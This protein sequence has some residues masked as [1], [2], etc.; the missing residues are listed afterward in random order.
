MSVQYI[1]LGED[2]NIKALRETILGVSSSIAGGIAMRRKQQ[3]DLAMQAMKAAHQNYLT[4]VGI[5]SRE[6]IHRENL[7][8]RKAEFNEEKNKK[9]DQVEAA[10]GLFDFFN[11]TGEDSYKYDSSG[12]IQLNPNSEELQKNLTKVRKNPS[13]ALS[14][15]PALKAQKEQ[16]KELL[17]RMRW[18]KAAYDTDKTGRLKQL[19][20][21]TGKE[22]N[23][24]S[25]QLSLP[26]VASLVKENSIWEELVKER[27]VG[28]ANISGL[29]KAQLDRHDDFL[30]VKN[31]FVVNGQSRI[32]E[33]WSL[34][35]TDQRSL[36]LAFKKQS[37]A[38][39]PRFNPKLQSHDSINAQ[40]AQI[41]DPEKAA[42]VN[43]TKLL[44]DLTIGRIPDA[45][46]RTGFIFG[47]PTDIVNRI[48]IN[49]DQGIKDLAQEIT[50]NTA[51]DKK[52]PPGP[53]GINVL[54]GNVDNDALTKKLREFNIF[55]LG[56]NKSDKQHRLH[57][58]QGMIL[59]DQPDPKSGLRPSDILLALTI[60]KQG[61]PGRYYGEFLHNE[62]N[63]SD[64]ARI[65]NNIRTGNVPLSDLFLVEIGNVKK[66]TAE[67]TAP[68]SYEESE[69]STPFM[70]QN[71]K[72]GYEKAPILGDKIQESFES[73]GISTDAET[74]K[75]LEGVFMDVLPEE[76]ILRGANNTL[77][78]MAGSI[79]NSLYSILV[80]Q[81]SREK[82]KGINKE[83]KKGGLI[84]KAIDGYM[85]VLVSPQ[86]FPVL[87]STIDEHI[88]TGKNWQSG[89]GSSLQTKVEELRTDGN[90]KNFIREMDQLVKLLSYRSSE[91]GW[92]RLNSI[93]LG[94]RR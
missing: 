79:D 63:L 38:F 59:G 39:D 23:N 71:A 42:S 5:E 30:K 80:N 55:E 10:E 9:K 43:T 64:A 65:G 66:N 24:E 54:L 85:N 81:Q 11:G 8:Q 84:D 76:S 3:N 1:E 22:I 61:I 6:K 89:T 70:M 13:V 51:V 41:S 58:I 62:D 12:H 26:L 29:N 67:E 34:F 40:I 88:K 92:N 27:I 21:A 17:S 28:T 56:G 72:G 35:N 37:Q 33:P 18:F 47:N 68:I 4:Q 60:K 73:I 45:S 57:A 46:R 91:D 7:A 32:N 25:G 52:T 2:P 44:T 93:L 53:A 19:V 77:R 36:S 15:I 87:S 48:K 14:A 94:R 69:L 49:I 82:L 90:H 74:F 86:R 31:H 50:S 20:T 78:H 16:R 83:T 75:T